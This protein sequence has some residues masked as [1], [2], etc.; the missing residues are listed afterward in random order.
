[1]WSRFPE[2]T[3]LNVKTR[4]ESNVRSSFFTLIHLTHASSHREQYRAESTFRIDL[5]DCQS[6]LS[7]SRFLEP[8]PRD[9]LDSARS[10]YPPWGNVSCRVG[11]QN[12]FNHT[13][14]TPQFRLVLIAHAHYLFTH[15]YCY[16]ARNPQFFALIGRRWTASRLVK[17]VLPFRSNNMCLVIC[18]TYLQMVTWLHTFV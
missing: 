14:S 11:S 12:L 4:R 15:A 7:T 10:Y 9:D 5:I 8:V 2:S 17:V 16:S 1:M 18:V 6:R 3:R 13:E